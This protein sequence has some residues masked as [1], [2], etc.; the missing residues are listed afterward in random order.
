MMMASCSL[1]VHVW[2]TTMKLKMSWKLLDKLPANIHFNH[3]RPSALCGCQVFFVQCWVLF[4]LFVSVF[5]HPVIKSWNFLPEVQKGLTNKIVY[6][7]LVKFKFHFDF[8]FL[9]TKKFLVFLFLFLVKKNF[10]P[11]DSRLGRCFPFPKGKKLL[12][13]NSTLKKVLETSYLLYDILY[14]P[15]V[16]TSI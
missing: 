10:I 8:L 14:V 2:R 15:Q 13:R 11:L 9:I 3:T 5:H 6:I 16:L 4:L 7:F 12:Q 1:F